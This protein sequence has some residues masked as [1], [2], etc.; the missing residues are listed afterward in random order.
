M[1]AACGAMGILCT[2]V[3]SVPILDNLLTRLL[4]VSVQEI[5]NVARIGGNRRVLSLCGEVNKKKKQ[6][7]KTSNAFIHLSKHYRPDG[8]KDERE[9][10]Y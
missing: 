2:D 10:E 5:C 9:E 7:K 8:R 6:K 1:F 3:V 4:E